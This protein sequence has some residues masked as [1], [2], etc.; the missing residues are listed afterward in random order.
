MKPGLLK[1]ILLAGL[2]AGLLDILAAIKGNAVGTF[3]FIASGVFGEAAFAGGTDMVAWGIFFHFFIAISFAAL[4]FLIYPKNALM[5][6]NKWI[7]GLLYGGLFV[8]AVMNLGVLPL[9]QAPQ[10]AFNWSGVLTN[11]AILAVCIGWPIAWLADKYY[12]L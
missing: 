6:K 1:N 5:R 4:Y 10:A 2:L 11:M 12:K 8:W 7:S 9:T 3:K